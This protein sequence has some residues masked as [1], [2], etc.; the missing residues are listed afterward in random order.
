MLP[1]AAATLALVSASFLAASPMA[2]QDEDET[3]FSGTVDEVTAEAVI[4]TREILGNPAEHRTFVINL[5]TKVE[6][7]LAEGVRVTV[8]F[9]TSDEGMIAET[10]TVHH[11]I[12]KKKF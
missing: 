11:P 3:F 9:H 4:V 2:F 12:K 1:L 7:K 10:I 8:K 5:K 6:G